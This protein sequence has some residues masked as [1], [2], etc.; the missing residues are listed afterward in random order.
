LFVIEFWPFKKYVKKSFG[1]PRYLK[2]ENSLWENTKKCPNA[3]E[4]PIKAH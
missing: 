1:W 4:D 3:P 2:I